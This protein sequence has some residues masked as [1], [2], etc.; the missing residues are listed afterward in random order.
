MILVTGG[1]GFIGR[2][3]A[4]RLLAAGRSIVA[5]AQ[6][7]HGVSATKRVAAAVGRIPAGTHLE[8][9]E[10]DLTAPACGLTARDWQ[11]LR[12]TIETVVHCAGDARFEPEVLA[13]YVAG[14]ID[15][16]LRLLNGLAGGRLARWAH[17]S[18]AFVCG[19]RSGTVL[20]SESDV[21]QT[22]NNAYERVK[23]DS[24]R[25]IRRAG[26]RRGVD[27]RVFRPSI[28]VGAAPP[29]AGGNP[30]NLFFRFIRIL[31]AFARLPHGR[32]LRLRVHG[33]PRARFNI[34]PVEYVAA[35]LVALAEEPEAAGKTFHLVARGAPTQA[36]ILRLI[37][38]RL[39]V[40]GVTLVDAQSGP[41]VDPSPI[42]RAVARMVE[43]YRA[44]L[45]QDVRFDD[46]TAARLLA[47]CGVARPRLSSNAVHRLVEHA[48]LTEVPGREVVMGGELTCSARARE[49]KASR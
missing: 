36:M 16:P 46:T 14:H 49:W 20:E 13:P 47:R 31:A 22:F 30:S 25:A 9:V 17:L 33:A 45:T 7:S 10:G 41:L 42:E 23:L 2:Q 5:L 29:T 12:A 21:G 38:R 39:G 48:R 27:I 34:V 8:V 44:Y 1:T 15:G 18:T 32:A 40:Q 35:A 26:A 4:R 6:P 19:R 43:P 24:E 3:V 28:V 11:R 37:T